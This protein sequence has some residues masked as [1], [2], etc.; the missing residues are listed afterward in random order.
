[1]GL[2]SPTSAVI[3]GISSIGFIGFLV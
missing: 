3:S 2:L 1:L